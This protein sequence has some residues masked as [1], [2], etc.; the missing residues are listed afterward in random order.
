MSFWKNL[1][2]VAPK[3]ATHASVPPHSQLSS[4]H[5]QHSKSASVNPLGTRREMLRVVLRDTLTRHGIPYAWIAGETLTATSRGREPGI[6]WR[7]VLKHW[8]PRLMLHGVALQ[9]SL[10]KR[11]MTFDPMASNWLMGISWQFAFED[12]SLCP[13]M[14]HAGLWTAQAPVA[15]PPAYPLPPA[16]VESALQISGVPLRPTADPEV[17]SARADLERLLAV[18]DEELRRHSLS[19]AA[20][21]PMFI[22]TEPAKF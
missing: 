11:V 8:D 19:A 1:F 7:L 6:H 5:S 16:S 20:T 22:P 21:Q 3:R 13:A 4:G 15:A 18:R 2:G 14:P 10:I 12:E 9:N 17:A